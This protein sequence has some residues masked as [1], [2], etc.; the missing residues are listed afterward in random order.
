M[1][2]QNATMPEGDPFFVTASHNNNTMLR[3]ARNKPIERA[4]L[5]QLLR[6]ERGLGNRKRAT[7][8]SFNGELILNRNRLP[9]PPIGVTYGHGLFKNDY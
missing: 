8:L 7:R 4:E 9:P 3:A 1:P 5:G 2:E 6:T